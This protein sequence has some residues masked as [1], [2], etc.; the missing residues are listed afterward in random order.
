MGVGDISQIAEGVPSYVDLGKVELT[1]E[2]R[3]GLLKG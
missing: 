3:R 1:G 2:Q